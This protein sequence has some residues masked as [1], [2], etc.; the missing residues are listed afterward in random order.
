MSRL[1]DEQWVMIEDSI[2]KKK[3][4]RGSRNRKTHCGKGGSVK[5]PSDYMTRKEINAMNGDVKSYNLNKPMDWKTLRSMP[6]DLQI[7]YIKKLRIT[8]D[9]P[10]STL[11]EALGVSKG[12]FSKYLID[13][14]IASGKDAG[15]KHKGWHK[16]EKATRFHSWWTQSQ[17]KAVEDAIDIPEEMPKVEAPKITLADRTQFEVECPVP[18]EGTLRFESV[19]AEEASKMIKAILGETRVRL[20]LNWNTV[21]ELTCVKE[22]LT[23]SRINHTKED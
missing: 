6:K 4:A 23:D 11:A 5:F 13:L 1:P 8:Y 14:G 17:Y 21:R 16:T 2:N 3:I 20:S 22:D 12:Y 18:G 10:D 19:T 15:S 7:T 9:V